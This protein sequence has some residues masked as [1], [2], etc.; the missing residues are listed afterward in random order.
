MGIMKLA[1]QHSQSGDGAGSRERSDE[2]RRDEEA[3]SRLDN[4]G[5]ANGGPQTH[6]GAVGS[7]PG[8]MYAA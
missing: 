4:E 2:R 1:F 3:W 5:S 7:A 6:A 8:V